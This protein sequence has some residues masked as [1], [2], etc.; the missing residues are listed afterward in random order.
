M[1]TKKIEV[2]Y[3][4]LNGINGTF[5]TINI[6]AKPDMTPSDIFY[7]ILKKHKKDK[8]ITE[9]KLLDCEKLKSGL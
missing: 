7:A 2:N 4:I 3:Y 1:E 8:N 9:L 5:S 6:N